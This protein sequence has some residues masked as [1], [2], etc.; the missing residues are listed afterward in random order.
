M[1]TPYI[2]IKVI[3]NNNNIVNTTSLYDDNDNNNIVITNDNKPIYE[4]VRYNVVRRTYILRI[5]YPRMLMS[6][7]A[8]IVWEKK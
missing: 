8:Y 6:I 1:R 2:T 3:P 7:D 5:K 4:G